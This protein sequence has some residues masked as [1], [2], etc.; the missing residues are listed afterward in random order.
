MPLLRGLRLLNAIE[1][2]NTSGPCIETLLTSDGGRCSDFVGVVNDYGHAC[3]MTSSTLTMNCIFGSNAATSVIFSNGN[4]KN[5]VLCSQTCGGSYAATTAYVNSPCAMTTLACCPAC[6]C[7]YLNSSTSCFCSCFWG[8]A[9]AV[10]AFSTTTCSLN[11]FNTCHNILCCF[12]LGSCAPC[13]SVKLNPW[14]GAPSPNTTTCTYVVCN[15]AC[16]CCCCCSYPLIF[17]GTNMNPDFFTAVCICSGVTGYQSWFYSNCIT[18]PCAWCSYP[19]C[20]GCTIA[21]GVMSLDCGNS[22]CPVAYSGSSATTLMYVCGC[23]SC[24]ACQ[25]YTYGNYVVIPGLNS[26]YNGYL[27][28]Q[29]LCNGSQNILCQNFNGNFIVTCINISYLSSQT[30]GS[31]I[32]CYSSWVAWGCCNSSAFIGFPCNFGSSYAPGCNMCQNSSNCPVAGAAC[33]ACFGG[34]WFN[35]NCSTYYYVNC[36]CGPVVQVCCCSALCGVNMACDLGGTTVAIR[37][38]SPVMLTSNYLTWSCGTN[39]PCCFMSSIRQ[40]AVISTSLAIAWPCTGCC[41]AY[42]TNQGC[43]WTGIAL[44]ICPSGGWQCLC[45]NGS[46]IAS[47]P[48]GCTC[49][50]IMSTTTNYAT[51]W[52][53]N[54]L[55]SC[56]CWIL[57]P[58][59]ATN[60]CYW[61]A[62]GNQC[63]LACIW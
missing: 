36:N 57:A 7:Q 61:V 47:I 50:V 6:F 37:G 1:T 35:C 20:A 48:R 55:P 40:I 30:S 43:T 21:G 31:C 33:S 4:A 17:L 51:T 39:T 58:V 12:L 10:A 13:W 24:T 45:V 59:A 41:A 5:L 3:A 42:T 15:P 60:Y 38:T 25:V 28:S 44:P 53:L 27:M 19:C 49:N 9:N 22:W 62:I 54:C 34:I 14:V 52:T 56:E 16:S 18:N 8:S 32:P 23:N 2:G 63:C 26:C 11:T 29:N 46:C